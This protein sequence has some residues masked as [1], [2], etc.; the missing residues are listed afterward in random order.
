MGII[1][2]LF[3]KIRQSGEFLRHTQ[4]P[5]NLILDSFRLKCRPFVAVADGLKL[6]LLPGSGESFTF[7]ENLIRRDYLQHGIHVKSGDTVLDVG[8]NIGAFTVVAAR[9][10]G[11]AGR[12][13]AMEPCS[14]TCRRL[15]HNVKLNGL[16]NVTVLQCAVGGSCGE[17]RLSVAEKSAYASLY[18]GCDGR[19]ATA[20]SEAV[21][22]RTLDDVMESLKVD[23]VSLLKL[24]CEGAEYDILAALH[25]AAASRIDQVSMEVHAIP[26]HQREEILA[27]LQRLGFSPKSTY[28]LTAFRDRCP[29]CGNSGPQSAQ[30]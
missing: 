23:H 5:G 28:P 1:S 14:E 25:P 12:V 10:V 26:G 17:M 30:G 8:A 3:E 24:D 19:Q 18:T 11:P 22:V 7:Y 6:S 13:I 21:R 9:Q 2:R 15:E 4:T 27:A 16:H 29:E 20:M